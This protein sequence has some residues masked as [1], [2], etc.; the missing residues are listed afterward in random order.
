MKRMKD[1][2]RSVLLLLAVLW[3]CLNLQAADRPEKSVLNVQTDDLSLVLGT[4]S[5]SSLMFHYFGPRL[6]DVSPFRNKQTYRRADYGTDDPAYAAAGGRNLLY[7]ALRM[8]HADGNLNTEL[9]YVGA[10]TTDSSDPNVTET[11]VLLR[12]RFYPLEVKLI[13]RTYAR[14]NVITERVEITNH[15]KKTVVLHHYYS[16]FLPVKAQKYYLNHFHGAWAQEMTLEE[17]LLTHGIKSVESRKGVRT[18]HHENPSFLLALDRPMDENYGEVIGG[19]LAWSGN[20][21]LNFEMNE[22][23]ELYISAG[24]NPYASEYR[25]SPGESFRTPE[26]VFTY[27]CEGA[28]GVTR[29]LHDWAR[30]YQVYDAQTIRPTLLNSW[31]GAYFDFDEKTLTDMIDDAAEMGLEMFVL[32]DGWFGNKYPRNDAKGGLGD[33]EVNHAKLPRGIGYLADY[34]VSKGLRFGIWIEPEMVNPRSELAERHPDWIV[35]SKGGT[36]TTIRSQ[37][38]L[39]LTNPEVQDF[40]FGVFDGVMQQSPNITYIKWDANRHVENVGSE[41]LPDDQQERF[42]VDYIQGLY[43]V[44]ERIRAKYPRVIVQ[45]CSSGGGRVDYGALKY[46]QEVW[47]SDNTDALSRVYIQYGTNL[48]YPALVT[49]AHVSASPNH[50]TGNVM[51]LKF[52]FDLAMSG[53]LGMELQPRQMSEQEREMAKGAIADYKRIRD[54]VM[55]GDLYRIE[56][57]YAG[58]GYYSLMYVSKDKKRAVAYG[59]CLQYQGRTVTPRFRLR[60]LDPEKRY[61]ITELNTRKSSFWGNGKLFGGDYLIREG[62]NPKLQKCGESAVFLIEEVE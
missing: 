5:D 35:R 31:E 9:I 3:P 29:N 27:S 11:T 30:N 21:R 49:G 6:A 39:D 40:V 47:T 1:V 25:L 10:T 50:Q 45:A 59:Y 15:E 43:S 32:D 4:A 18:T 14:E 22:S 7:P 16:A 38:L 17:T 55:F 36:A 60:G 46:H 8:T 28:G 34:A 56:S 57:P 54:L 51:P 61:R 2:M 52:R 19:A 12:D 58:T 42:W 48:I 24:I 26:M 62:I 20:Y 41:Y 53:R 44:Y 13:F 37:W 33:W 23:N